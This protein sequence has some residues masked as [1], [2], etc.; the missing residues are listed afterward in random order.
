MHLW[1]IRP[2]VRNAFD[3]GSIHYLGKREG[4]GPWES[5]VFWALWSGMEP[6]GE[7]HL[8]PKKLAQVRDQNHYA[9]GRINHSCI[10]GFMYWRRI[11]FT[12]HGDI[13]FLIV[14]SK[15]KPVWMGGGGG[16]GGAGLLSS[17]MHLLPSPTLKSRRWVAD[18]KLP[19]QRT[20]N[21]LE[22]RSWSWRVYEYNHGWRK[23]RG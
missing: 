14:P 6:M 20:Y 13:D 2:R 23:W 17:F 18:V 16:G 19:F 8:G 4:V 15:K 9:Q 21:L 11:L 7:C 10:G 1:F 5:R 3:A 22:F 12:I